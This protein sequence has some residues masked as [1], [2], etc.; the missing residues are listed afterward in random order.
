MYHSFGSS[1]MSEVAIKDP[2][3]ASYHTLKIDIH[4]VFSILEG[5]PGKRN[6]TLLLRCEEQTSPERVVC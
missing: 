4:W 5:T 1:S 3:N 2:K 6:R